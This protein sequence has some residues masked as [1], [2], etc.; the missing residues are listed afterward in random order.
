DALMLRQDELQLGRGET[1]A[2]T[3]RVL[4]RYVNGIMI[5]T[6]RQSDV[7]ALAEHGDVP[8][9]NGLTDREH[10]CQVLTDLYT[11]RQRFSDWTEVKTAFV[12]DGNNVA[13]S[14]LL[15][16]G[17]LGLSFALATPEAY[18]PDAGILKRARELA[19]ASGGEI[20]VG[21]DPKE[22]VRGARVV[23]TDTWVS[24]G[25]EQE[26][27][28]RLPKF[29]GFQVNAGLLSAADPRA[30]VMHCLPA[31]RGEEITDEVMDGPQSV[32]FDQAENRLH[33][34]KGLLATLLADGS[35]ER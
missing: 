27:K 20:A 23:Y 9:I 15:A 35:R 11:I 24:M 30:I 22:A 1:V 28:E 29:E 19:A 4:S 21:H 13:N 2:D 33:V 26:R 6:F 12:G 10:P 7:E 3:A 5:R 17:K 14:W 32:V 18:P 25:A 16:A 8:V 31:H 34:Q